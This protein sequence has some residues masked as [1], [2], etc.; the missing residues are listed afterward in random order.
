MRNKI[1]HLCEHQVATTTANLYTC[2]IGLYGG[3]PY[4]GNCIT[5][6]AN[7]ENNAEHFE[8]LKKREA[9][10]HPPQARRISGC[11]DSALNPSV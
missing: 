2:S 6:M 5:C 7:A 4:L 10:S 3:H 1:T 8:Q 9:I 11:C